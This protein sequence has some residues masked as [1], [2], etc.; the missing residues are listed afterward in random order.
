MEHIVVVDDGVEPEEDVEATDEEIASEVVEELVEEG[1]VEVDAALKL[2][3]AVEM[4]R[5][6]GVDT[7]EV[8]EELMTVAEEDV[9]EAEE[10]VTEAVAEDEAEENVTEAEDATVADVEEVVVVVDVAG[11][12]GGCKSIAPSVAAS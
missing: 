5:V 12:T 4:T 7:P 6:V 3:A 8:E 1:R 2:V 9:T 11:V 10:N